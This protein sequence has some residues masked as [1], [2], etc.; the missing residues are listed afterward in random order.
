MSY[1]VTPLMT[2]S[3]STTVETPAAF[4]IRSRTAAVAGENLSSC[5]PNRQPRIIEPRHALL[6]F[7]VS[8]LLPQAA[9]RSA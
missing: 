8:P 7:V 5:L 3:G 4:M 6:D 9:R 1:W 2:F